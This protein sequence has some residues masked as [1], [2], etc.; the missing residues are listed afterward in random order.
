M[1]ICVHSERHFHL[2]VVPAH[3]L[4]HDAD[5]AVIL[6]DVILVNYD[7]LAR[8]IV[9][10]FSHQDGI[11]ALRTDAPVPVG[12][13]GGGMEGGGMEGGGGGSMSVSGGEDKGPRA[14]L[15]VSQTRC[16]RRVYLKRRNVNRGDRGH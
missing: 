16:N 7:F 15:K 4:V 1:P 14:A 13:R 8:L 5:I 3:P 2:A 11:L 10:S 9:D 12:G 6:C